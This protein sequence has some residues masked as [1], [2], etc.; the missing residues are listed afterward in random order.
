MSRSRPPDPAENSQSC[1]SLPRL[2]VNVSGP[3]DQS[4]ELLVLRLGAASAFPS[5]P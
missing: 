3:M 5:R 2:A 1:A 4:L